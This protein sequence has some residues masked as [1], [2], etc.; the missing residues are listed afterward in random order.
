MQ[1]GYS[2]CMAVAF[3]QRDERPRELNVLVKRFP[4]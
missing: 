2:Y 4:G 1:A 3:L